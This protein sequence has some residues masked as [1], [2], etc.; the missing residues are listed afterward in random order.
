[1]AMVEEDPD[2]FFESYVPGLS[3]AS[4]AAF[5]GRYLQKMVHVLKQLDTDSSGIDAAFGGLEQT[6]EFPDLLPPEI[7]FFNLLQTF[8]RS[9][10]PVWSSVPEGYHSCLL[11]RG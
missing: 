10:R 4:E 6:N 2:P 11:F 5:T 9:F 1:M 8:E 3:V 7:E